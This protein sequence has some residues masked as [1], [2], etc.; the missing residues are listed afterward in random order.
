MSLWILYTAVIEWHFLIK[1]FLNKNN[2]AQKKEQKM[3]LYFSR[4]ILCVDHEYT[5]F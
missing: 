4:D 1:P 5:M 2:A 3:R